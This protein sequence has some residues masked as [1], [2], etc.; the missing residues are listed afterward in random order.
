MKPRYIHFVFF[1]FILSC[2][3]SLPDL[4]AQTYYVSPSGSD[5]NPGNFR[6]PFATVSRAAE[7]LQ[8]GDTCILRAGIYRETFRPQNSGMP[9]AAIVFMPYEGEKVIISGADEL[10]GYFNKEGVYHIP[11]PWDLEDENQ[12]FANGIMMHEATWPS[13]GD[14]PLFQPVRASAD[15]GTSTSLQC[16]EIPGTDDVWKGAELWCAGGK[17][18]ICWTTDITGYDAASQ[19]LSFKQKKESW[20]KPEKGNLFV[21]RGISYALN[22]PGEWH[23][24]RRKQQLQFIPPAEVNSETMLLE[25][26]RRKDA[27]DL[28]NRSFIHIEGIT[29]HSGGIRMDD[30]SHHNTLKN[31]K[32]MYVSHS[33]RNDVSNESG[34]LI[35]GHH[36]LVLNC[37]F[38]YSSASVLSVKG[39][40]NRV[41][42]CK[43][44]HGGYAG[45]WRGTVSLT[46]RRIVFSHNTVKHAG[47]DLVNTHGLMESLVQYNDVSEAGWLTKDLGMFYGHNTDYAN[48]VFRYNHVHDNRAVHLNMG[49]YFDHLS[50]NAIVHN[51]VIW[52]TSWD[53]IRFNNPSY[54]NLVFNNTCWNTGKITTFDHAGRDD[55]FASRFFNNIFNEPVTLPEHVNVY[56]N[57]IDEHPPFVDTVQ[58]DFRLDTAVKGIGAY[59][60]QEGY[61]TAGYRPGHPPRPLPVYEPPH[62]HWMNMVYNACFEFGT[63]EG[64][65]KTGA[66]NA[67]LVEGNWWGT[68]LSSGES[69]PTGTSEYELR[70]GPEKD[71]VMQEI[72]GLYP[73]TTYTLSAWLKVGKPG[74]KVVL[75]VSGYGSEEKS[76]TGTAQEWTRKNVT[77]ATGDDD[78]T[79]II[80]LQ[81]P[82]NGD[83]FV[84][85][86]NL[87]LPLQP[88]NS[89]N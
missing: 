22:D 40:G 36:N 37:D 1:L 24:N 5:T 78:T 26:K 23:Y 2:Y 48:T 70:L 16:N 6:H 30:D 43:I 64:W 63:L 84:W 68:S 34:I 87:T 60:T 69:A 73:N 32:G 75:G 65:N 86:D 39:K 67:T 77:F 4:Q 51:N 42:N 33:Y 58:K 45:L 88:D 20:Y 38:G 41:I 82:T 10:S 7:L 28:S 66:L 61:W 54:C 8:P 83:G 49:I 55:L 71:G 46:G 18:W 62:I 35:R 19:T 85:C 12:I 56:H 13:L 79:A 50:N 89:K 11:M 76:V 29:I 25:A 21:L 17:S 14:K 47:R 27:I 57:L 44:T 3:V 59:A 52:N 31:V 15:D 53:P 74:E 72:K 80:F 9:G 81:K